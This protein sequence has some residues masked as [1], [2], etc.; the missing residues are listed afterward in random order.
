MT[1]NT[2]TPGNDTGLR[3]KQAQRDAY[4]ETDTQLIAMEG[5][6]CALDMLEDELEIADPQTRT[7]KAFFV[8]SRLTRQTM[9]EIWKT[10]KGEWRSLGGKF[11]RDGDR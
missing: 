1:N 3:D 9:A 4:E 6:L 7:A 10:R 11:A 2:P 8:L 5:L